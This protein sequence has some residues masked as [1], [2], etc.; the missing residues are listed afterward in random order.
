MYI[1]HVGDFVSNPKL[2]MQGITHVF[3]VTF[4]PGVLS[5]FKPF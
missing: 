1:L 4:K 5:R 2:K 3:N